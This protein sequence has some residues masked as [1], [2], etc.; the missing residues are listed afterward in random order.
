MQAV[1][2]ERALQLGIAVCLLA[3]VY[4]V[5]SSFHERIVA[6]G[7]SAPDFAITADNGRTVTRANFGGKLLVLN[8][9]ATWCP[10]C[11]QEI[12]SLD[13]FQKSFSSAGVVVLGISVDQ[14]PQAYREFLAKAKVAFLTARDPESKISADYG[15]Y[16]YPETYIINSKGQ[17]VEKFI[18][19]VNWTDPDIASR[20]KSLL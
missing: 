5:Y 6:A 1:K 11:V 19:P 10:P 20:V 7:D 15:T 16:K 3:L 8:F 4:G 18:G 13:Q 14:S 2:T 17:V 9:W 12:P